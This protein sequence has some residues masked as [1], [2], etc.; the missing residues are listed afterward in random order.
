MQTSLQE[1]VN[2]KC[3]ILFIIRQFAW[4]VLSIFYI[5]LRKK[6]KK[7]NNN[8]KKKKHFKM[9]F[10]EILTQHANH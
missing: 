9:L 1:T 10:A 7:K 4:N 8:K 2:M 3:Q 6:K 5:F